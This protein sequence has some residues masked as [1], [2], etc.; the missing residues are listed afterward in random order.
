MTKSW[1]VILGALLLIAFLASSSAI[2]GD[3]LDAASEVV[4]PERNPYKVRMN[5]ALDSRAFDAASSQQILRD[6]DFAAQRYVGDLWE[7]KVQ[8]VAWLSPV[9][10]AGLARTELSQFIDEAPEKTADIW[11]AATLESHAA[12]TRISVRSWQPEVRTETAMESVEVVDRREIATSLLRL[13]RDLVRPIGT[14][15]QVNDRSVQIRLRAGEIPSPDSS[16]DQLRKGDVLLPLMAFRGKKGVVERMQPIPWTYITVDEIDGSTVQGSVQSGLRLALGGK[17]RGRIDTLVVALR[18]QQSATKVELLTQSKPQRPLVAHRIEVRTEP[19]IPRSKEGESEVDPNSTLIAEL[20]TDRRGQARIPAVKG[21][22]MVWLFAFSGQ[23]LLARVPFV[24]GLRHEVALEVPD[25]ATRLAA[26]A[27]LQM[28]QAE[29]VDAVALRNTAIAL[30]RAAAKK[31]D[32]NTV[33][34]RLDVIKRQKD[35]GSFSDRLTAVRVAGVAAARSRKDKSAETRIQRMCDELK[36]LISA[37]LGDDKITAISDEMEAL[38][39][40]DKKSDEKP[41]A[42]P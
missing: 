40:A 27:D 16:F 21:R 28:L 14:V 17:K 26:E 20:L 5:V 1:S 42:N 3:G 39:N 25:D 7:L 13:C 33:N 30:I 6:I 11:F 8:Q 23:N 19:V 9:S 36:E 10:S 32:W 15:E 31:D 24:P 12:A 2:A 4:A 22:S 41:P 18:P 35:A 29:I 37:H 38:Q 34:Q